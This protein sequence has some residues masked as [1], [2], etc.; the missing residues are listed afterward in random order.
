MASGGTIKEGYLFKKGRIN[1]DWRE[2]LFVLNA[3]QLAYFKGGVSSG[4]AQ[5]FAVCVTSRRRVFVVVL[6][7]SACS[8]IHALVLTVL[9][10]LP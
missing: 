7:R 5:A 1:T 8:G 9:A 3:K 6:L 4:K 2:R 10:R